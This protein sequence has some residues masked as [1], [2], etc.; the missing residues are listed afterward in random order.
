MTDTGLQFGCLDDEIPGVLRLENEYE[1]LFTIETQLDAH[2]TTG[3]TVV[4]VGPAVPSF[5]SG[6]KNKKNKK[7]VQIYISHNVACEFTCHTL[8]S[9]C[10]RN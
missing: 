4:V 3:V 1:A 5:S 9:N 10:C 8:F 6:Y 2:F 7:H